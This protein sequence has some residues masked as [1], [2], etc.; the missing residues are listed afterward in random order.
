MV[1]LWAVYLVVRW[2]DTTAARWV[3]SKAA[4]RAA[5]LVE[6]RVVRWER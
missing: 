5:L 3:G 4:W 1:V 6:M 2:V